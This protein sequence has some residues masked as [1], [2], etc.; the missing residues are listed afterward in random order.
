MGCRVSEF[1]ALPVLPQMAHDVNSPR[2]CPS[3]EPNKHAKPVAASGAVRGSRL[4]VTPTALDRCW[5]PDTHA[6]RTTGVSGSPPGRWA[7]N[8]A[9]SR[10]HREELEAKPRTNPAEGFGDTIP[11]SLFCYV[12]PVASDHFFDFIHTIGGT[13]QMMSDLGVEHR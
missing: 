6:R 8:P 1:R 4:L 11:T 10:P 7:C 3:L 5:V 13:G 12:S 2:G 9:F